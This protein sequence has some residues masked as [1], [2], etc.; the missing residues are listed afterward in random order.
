[1]PVDTKQIT[2]RRTLHFSSLAE[3]LSDC[4]HLAAVPVTS[5]GNWSLGQCLLHLAE[6]VKMPL[7]GAPFQPPWWLKLIGPLLKRRF[8]WKPMSAGF[9]LPRSA[10]KLLPGDGT[11]TA[12]GLAALRQA[13]DRFQREPQRHPHGFLGKLSN[14][15]W[16]QT[17]CRHA[18]LHL[19]F[20][21]P[22]PGA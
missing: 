6:A 11:S 5:L 18:E 1:M 4:E 10:A 16:E 17:Q 3:V 19:S 9:Q 15:E 2:G 8:V 21:V 20:H 14:E 12:E 7:D 13:I 22:R